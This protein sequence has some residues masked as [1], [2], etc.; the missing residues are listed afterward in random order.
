MRV[1]RDARPCKHIE[2]QQPHTLASSKDIKAHGGALTSTMP[3]TQA[4]NVGHVSQDVGL[5]FVGDFAES[6]IVE[7]AGVAGNAGD[8]H[9]GVEKTSILL[10][11]IVVDQSGSGVHLKG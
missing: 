8:E 9:V 6:G 4:A 1:D 3:P 5:V 10:Q 7:T 2:K 11:S